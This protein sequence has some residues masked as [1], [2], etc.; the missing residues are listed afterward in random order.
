MENQTTTNLSIVEVEGVHGYVDE[1]G[2]VQLLVDDVARGLGF[3]QTKNGLDYIR[4]ETV[5]GYISEF[6][7][8]PQMGNFSQ[9]V[10]NFP[11]KVGK[12]DYIPEQAFYLLAMKA[13]NEAARNFQFKVAFKIMP[14]IRK[15]GYYSLTKETS[16]AVKVADEKPDLARV[17][18]L[19]L[20][21]DTVQIVKIGHSKN[22]RARVAKIERETGL[23]VVDM[24]F[25]SYMPRED[26]RLVEWATQKVLS[27]WRVEG[28]FFS[29]DFFKAR[30]TIKRFVKLTA[31]KFPNQSANLI[32]D[33]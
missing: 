16:P 25:T 3:T 9:E 12:G 27:P 31:A 1:N 32:A 22:I 14:S 28:E 10:G 2:I 19:K 15:Y 5:N 8:S 4:W 26:A 21:D 24:Y 30:A 6:S 33:K 7:F 13:S 11:K 20:S 29:V 17:Y 23:T 18:L